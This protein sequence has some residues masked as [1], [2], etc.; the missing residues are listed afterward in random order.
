MF[1]VYVS[2][3]VAPF[4]SKNCAFSIAPAVDPQVVNSGEIVAGRSTF[5]IASSIGAASN[6]RGFAFVQMMDPNSPD[7]QQVFSVAASLSFSVDSN[8]IP[9]VVRF[10]SPAA[11]PTSFNISAS[12]F[13]PVEASAL[14]PRALSV[15]DCVTVDVKPRAEGNNVFV[16]VVFFSA[17]ANA[18]NVTGVVSMAQVDHEVTTLQP[19]K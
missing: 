7:S 18:G 15:R 5:R 14:S 16:G 1:Q 10:E 11:Q 12:D 4:T 3:H 8:Y 6:G 2:K 13:I 17:A 9:C 19:L